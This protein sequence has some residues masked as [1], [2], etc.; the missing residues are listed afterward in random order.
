LIEATSA[1]GYRRLAERDLPRALAYLDRADAAGLGTAVAKAAVTIDWAVDRETGALRAIEDVYT[2]SPA[3]KTL[4]A[5]RIAQWALYRVALRSQLDG[6][7]K[8]RATPLALKVVPAPVV[9]PLEK[10]YGAVV[11]SIDPG[12]KGRE[13]SLQTNERYAAYLKEHPD[14]LKA[15]GLTPPLASTVLNYVNG[16]RSIVSIRNAV[17]AETGQDV[18]LSAVAGYLDLLKA[19]R[20]VAY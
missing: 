18:P 13:F 12:V 10:Q 3:A 2:A 7:A 11:P 6:Y 16:R 9:D 15:L 19:V 5:N 14:T 8:V 17:V 20:W 4:L 1:L